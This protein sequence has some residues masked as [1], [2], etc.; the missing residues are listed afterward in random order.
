M[1]A[2]LHI[3]DLNYQ[4]FK[5]FDLAINDYKMVSI[6]GSNN[7]GKSTLFKVISGV[8][9]T[10]SVVRCLGI[11]LNR[12]NVNKYIKQLGIVYPL[13]EYAFLFD[14]VYD[15]LSYPLKNLGYSKIYV[16]RQINKVLNLFS[17][18]IKDKKINELTVEEKQLLIFCLALIH[19]PKVLLIDDVF[20]YMNETDSK[21]IITILKGI[22]K[23]AII[24][25]SSNL[26]NYKE[27]DYIYVLDNGKIKLEGKYQNVLKED[28]ILKKIGLEIPFTINLSNKLKEVGI[29]NSDYDNL[30]ELVNEV[31]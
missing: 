10:T 24:N 13:Q 7:S 6:I 22:K 25:F 28:N 8:I 3:N 21:K 5:D 31:W 12:Q 1:E 17:L 19:N 18:D 2:V 4:V 11:D 30:E 9:P 20:S 23:I 16:N 14:T 29:I 26:D 27:N 15:E